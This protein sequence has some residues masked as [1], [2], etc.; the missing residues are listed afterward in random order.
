MKIENPN[1]REREGGIVFGFGFGRF[2]C[3]LLLKNNTLLIKMPYK[4][5]ERLLHK[6][7]S[8]IVKEFRCYYT[9]LHI[10]IIDY[11]SFISPKKRMLKSHRGNKTNSKRLK[12]LKNSKTYFVETENWKYCSKIIFKCVN[13]A[14]GPIFNEKIDK[15]WNLWVC[16][17]CIYALFTAES[18]WTVTAIL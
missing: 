2:G 17:Q 14:M 15:K 1:K 5:S 3:L 18:Q 10:G 12:I 8:P 11:D 13:S 7:S 6:S 16:E 9:T 4:R